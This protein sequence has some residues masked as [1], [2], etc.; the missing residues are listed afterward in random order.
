MKINEVVLKENEYR[1]F[2]IEGIDGNWTVVRGA[3][4]MKCGFT[5]INNEL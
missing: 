3:D 2:K 5:L 4:S 1:C